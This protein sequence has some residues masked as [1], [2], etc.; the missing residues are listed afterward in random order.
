MAS[1]RMEPAGV[2]LEIPEA[3]RELAARHASP[4]MDSAELSYLAAALQLVPWTSEAIVVEIGA[5]RGNT[6][7]FMARVLDALGRD[8]PILSVDPFDRAETDE[9]NPQGSLAE[10][11]SRIDAEGLAERCLPLVAFSEAAA[12]VVPERIGLLM[13]D[14]SHHYAAVKNDLTLYAEK[15]IPGGIIFIDDYLPPYDGV[16]QA[17]DE[18]LEDR[19]EFHVLH[20]AWFVILQKQ[21]RPT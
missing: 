8:H 19:R 15:L 20:R 4:M 2:T 1:L 9:L 14:G 3:A 17:T 10:F 16:I 13:V 6:T 11:M 21:G 7:V 12:A 18:F 5:Y